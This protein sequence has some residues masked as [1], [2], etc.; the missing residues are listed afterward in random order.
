MPALFDSFPVSI[1][2][3][4]IGVYE[5]NFDVTG[6]YSLWKSDKLTVHEILQGLLERE[7]IKLIKCTLKFWSHIQ[8]TIFHEMKNKVNRYMSTLPV[9]FYLQKTRM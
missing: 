8:Q 1:K 9:I 3:I 7:L 2:V 6:C 5:I 4:Q